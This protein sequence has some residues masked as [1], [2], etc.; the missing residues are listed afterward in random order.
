MRDALTMIGGLDDFELLRSAHHLSG[1]HG[2]PDGLHCDR[3]L[4]V[5]QR[6][7]DTGDMAFWAKIQAITV[8]TWSRV[9]L[10][11]NPS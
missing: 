6:H 8:S 9:P 1:L 10:G 5:V 7:I 11:D 3:G 2:Q 4:L